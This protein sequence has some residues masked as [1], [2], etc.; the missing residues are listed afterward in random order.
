MNFSS[1]KG[2]IKKPE[3]PDR[4][5][6]ASAAILMTRNEDHTRRGQ[7]RTQMR[8]QFHS[9]H[10]FHPDIQDDKPHGICRHVIEESFWFPK[11]TC[12]E[13]LRFEQP[14]DG[15]SPRRIVV[16]QVAN[17]RGGNRRTLRRQF[18]F[19]LPGSYFE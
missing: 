8:Q 16:K 6:V 2:L 5:T 1:S 17:F 13:S 3:A 14:T 11:G 15:F 12:V 10:S 7:S 18:L 9:G 4:I 19:P